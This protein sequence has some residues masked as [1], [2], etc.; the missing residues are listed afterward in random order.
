MSLDTVI[1]NEPVKALLGQGLQSQRIGHAYIL[2]GKR[3]VGRMT[4]AKAFAAQLLQTQDPETHP[5]FIVV[6]NQRYDPSKKQE[7]LLVDTI[8]SMKRDIYIRPYAGQR[9]VY[10]L[11]HADTMQ[12]PAQNSLLKVFEDPPPYCVIILLAENA[13][14]F[15]PTILSRAPVLRMRTLT[16]EQVEKFLIEQRQIP[17]KKA[18]QLAVLSGGAI[19]RALELLEDEKAIALREETLQRLLAMC[20]GTYREMYDF[21]RFCRENRTDIALILEVLLSWNQDVLHQKLRLSNLQI[22]NGDKPKELSEFC[23]QITREAALRM[24][25]S[26]IKYQKMIEQNVNYSAAIL[27]MALEYWEEIHGRDY[28]S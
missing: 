9:K 3:G 21:V 6:T 24:N 8:R 28:R 7:T 26:T 27:C 15:L 4:M 14:G 22:I 23:G 10:V 20:G 11:P 12:A 5:D 25:D 17:P 19:G 16:A 2:E 18:E 1:G 13:N